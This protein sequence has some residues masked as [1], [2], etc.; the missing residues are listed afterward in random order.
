MEPCIVNE[1]RYFEKV[2]TKKTDY[3]LEESDE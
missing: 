1:I 3:E 2:W